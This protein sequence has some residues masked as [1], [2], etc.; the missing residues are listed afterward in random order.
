[1][2]SYL[3]LLVALSGFSMGAFAQTGYYCNCYHKDGSAIT[4]SIELDSKR[5][6]K[7][8]IWGEEGNLAAIGIAF[9]RVTRTHE[10]SELARKYIL[11]RDRVP[12]NLIYSAEVF[13]LFRH[14]VS[15]RERNIINFFDSKGELLYMTE[16]RG[17]RIMKCEGRTHG[18]QSFC[19]QY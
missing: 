17:E 10:V 12:T 9:R 8:V 19:S 6:I 18:P 7:K 1:M 2:K 14:P 5:V 11:S 4:A 13:K 15:L 3:S 16:E